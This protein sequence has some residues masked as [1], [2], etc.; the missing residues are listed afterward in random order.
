MNT[1]GWMVCPYIILRKGDNPYVVS[2]FLVGKGPRP[3]TSAEVKNDLISH[4]V[5]AFFEGIFPFHI[6]EA[7]CVFLLFLF[8]LFQLILVQ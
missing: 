4:L 6:E 1:L 3:R 8:N 5:C 2:L 7:V